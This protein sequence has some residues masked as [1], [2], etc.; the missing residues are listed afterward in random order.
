MQNPASFAETAMLVQQAIAQGETQSIEYLFNRDLVTPQDGEALLDAIP[1]FGVDENWQKLWCASTYAFLG[2]RDGVTRALT[3]A[4]GPLA[5]KFRALFGLAPW[6]AHWKT[7]TS[8]QMTWRYPQDNLPASVA[9]QKAAFHALSDFFGKPL[10]HDILVFLW[11]AR[12]EARKKLG[13]GLGF[14][15]P[16]YSLIHAAPDQSPG[17]ELAHLFAHAVPGTREKSAFVSEGVAVMLDQTGKNRVAEAKN[18]MARH[19]I[20]AIDVAALWQSFS[21]LPHSVSYPIAGLFC[22][23]LLAAHG[24]SGIF[25]LLR[26]PSYAE[27]RA[28]FGGNLVDLVARDV[29]KMFQW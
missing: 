20:S 11:P 5:E 17:H 18:A 28:H 26:H 23:R 12:D 6:Y 16:Q 19:G 1:A 3:D 15:I 27:A 25:E 13:R 9:A 7:H 29:E 2:R 21:S 10:D 22:A 4:H 14:A 24:K 8:T